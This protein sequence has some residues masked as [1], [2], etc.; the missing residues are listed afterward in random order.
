M[1]RSQ[2]VGSEADEE[3]N[4][5]Y[6]FLLSRGQIGLSVAFDLPSQ[7]GYDSHDPL[8]VEEVGRVGVAIDSLADT[9]ALLEGID[10]AKI[11][12]NLTINAP[13]AVIL[14]MYI[15]VGE[16]QGV[17]PKDLRGTLQNDILK[18][19]LARKT[20]IFPPQPSMR[21]KRAPAPCR[22]WP[23]P[24]PPRWPTWKRYSNGA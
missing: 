13:A 8:V 7:L 4:T 12:T 14:A 16:K 18:E 11:S 21:L 23:S 9:E 3:S 17:A 2:S 20:C 15:A 5:R 6:K 19:H 10:L 22:R 24:W 1:G